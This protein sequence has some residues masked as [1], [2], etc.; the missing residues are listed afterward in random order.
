MNYSDRTLSSRH[1]A[2]LLTAA[3]AT[4][5]AFWMRKWGYD[6]PYITYRYAVNIVQGMGF[7]Y[8]PGEAVLSTTTPLYAVFLAVF[9]IAGADLPRVSLLIGVVSLALG[10]LAL[11]HLGQGWGSPVAAWAGLLLYPFFP[12][13]ATTLGS[14]QPFTL[15][16]VLWG[17]VAYARRRYP[18]AAVL[19]ALGILARADSGVM[20]LILA[21]HFLVRRY[22]RTDNEFPWAAVAAGG[23]ILLVWSLFAW[24]YFGSPLPATLAAKRAQGLMSISQSYWVGFGMQA[25]LYWANPQYWLFLSSVGLGLLF[26]IR[27]AQWLPVV[28]WSGAHLVAYSLLGVTRYFWYYAQLVPGLIALAALGVE[29]AVAGAR[30]LAPRTPR[31]GS[32]QVMDH[33]KP[34]GPQTRLARVLSRPDFYPNVLAL[35]LILPMTGVELLSVRT[36]SQRSDQRLV[37]YQDVGEWLAAN[38]PADASVGTLEVGIIGYFA[39]RPMIDFAGLLQPDVAHVFGPNTTYDDTALWAIEHYRPDYLA[40]QVGSLPRTESDP[41]VTAACAS[42]H[43]VTQDGYPAPINILQCQWGKAGS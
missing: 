39:Q 5:L 22:R 21:F 29:A 12:L 9:R 18:A 30:R 3:S 13:L 25:R 35:L 8:N 26:L 10:G 36:I 23:A 34:A 42:V 43:T 37:V 40:I 33:E 2:W 11:W 32:S 14:E 1:W 20:A 15:A 16:L 17:T 41:Q 28:L 31:T 27:R 6:D 38:T 4:I 19:L 7:V 24:R